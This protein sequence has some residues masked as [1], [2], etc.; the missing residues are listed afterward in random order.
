[1]NNSSDTIAAIATAPGEAGIAIVRVSGPLSLKIADKIFRG[2][3]APLSQ[4]RSGNF[5]HGFIRSRADGEKRGSA[6]VDE[7]IVL[8]YRAPHSYTR[9]D[10]VEIQGHGGR[11]CAGR[12]L[13]ALLG[14]GAR[15]AEPG[16]FT[17]RAFL[18]GRI[19]LLQ[20][21]AVLDLIRAQSDRAGTAAVEQLEGR[22]SSAFNDGY[23][24]IMNVAVD[25]EATLDFPEEELPETEMRDLV[26]G[27]D[28][29]IELLKTL[30]D[31]WAEGRLLREGA[32]VVICGRPNAG[33]STLLN[34]LV[35]SNRVIVTDVPGTTR[36]TI[37][38][39]VILHGAPLR[40]VDTAGLRDAGCRIER[41]GVQRAQAC[42]EKADVVLYVVDS[43]VPL[44]AEDRK[45][46]CGIEP[47]RCILVLNKKDL[48]S[49]VSSDAFAGYSGLSCS[50]LD[51][52][53]IPSVR[54]AVAAKVGI[55]NCGLPH[56]VI[57]ERHR[58]IVHNVL[59]ELNN[60]RALLF[61]NRED[62][63]VLAATSLRSALEYLGTV[64]GKVYTSELL[65]SIFARFCVGK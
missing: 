47:R 60:A 59:N 20:A 31:T 22:L 37:E 23:D 43:S 48:G 49:K 32:L 45:S 8:I 6:A 53:D 57:S 41:E 19:D 38:E 11:T 34:R 36:D 28:K 2:G 54:D 39:Q 51:D 33:K 3:G 30:L 26:A 9:E 5:V 35:G 52:A 15:M 25:L 16:E 42:I 61:G 50:L 56:A 24:V 27:L 10:V 29:G 14:A 7:A 1:M 4:R 44:H 40:L 64:T 12:I 18:N 63:A 46:V 62:G 13:R 58:S 21:E 17:R 65:D 55:Q